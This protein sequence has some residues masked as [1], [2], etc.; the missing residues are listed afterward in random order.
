VTTICS[1]CKRVINQTVHSRGASH[2]DPELISHGICS[3]CLIILENKIREKPE[4]S[5]SFPAEQGFP[6]KP[7]TPG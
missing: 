3:K 4:F 1:Q 7:K 5:M 6:L 2:T